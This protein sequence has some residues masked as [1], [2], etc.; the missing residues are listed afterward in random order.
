MV[1]STG[2][3]LYWKGI[4]LP[5]YMTFSDLCEVAS[6]DRSPCRG[7]GL[8]VFTFNDHNVAR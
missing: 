6:F 4:S 3:K 2:K 8:A 7:F 1:L 5:G